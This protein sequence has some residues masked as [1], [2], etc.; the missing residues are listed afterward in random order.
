MFHQKIFK[1]EEK[2][3]HIF[4]PSADPPNPRHISALGL[5]IKNRK[6]RPESIIVMTNEH[7]CK[8]SGH[9]VVFIGLKKVPLV[10]WSK[11]ACNAFHEIFSLRLF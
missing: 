3:F 7:L 4:R 9:L 2:F 6:R 1:N 5:K 10:S 11:E 8:V